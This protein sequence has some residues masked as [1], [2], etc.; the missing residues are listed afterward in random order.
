M[1]PIDILTNAPRPVTLAGKSYPVRQLK[2]REWGEIQAWLKSVAPSPVAIAL[3]SVAAL[4][5]GGLPLDPELQKV[6]F[7]Q[8]QE[9]A[10]AWPPRVASPAWFKA[11][12]MMDG[13][14]VQ[15]VS[16][17]L[18]A[19]GTAV[20]EDDAADI[21][22][23]ATSAELVELVRVCVHGEHF[24]PKAGAAAATSRP[25]SPTT[26]DGSTNDSATS[27]ESPSPSSAS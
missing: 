9:E 13:G 7:A 14:H 16:L 1:Y 19:G 5:E 21:A 2:Y 11:V 6:L 27:E 20:S 22:R 24:I 10:R 17:A 26:G 18:R 12:D 3:K 8:A 4:K 25:P 23:E 15:L